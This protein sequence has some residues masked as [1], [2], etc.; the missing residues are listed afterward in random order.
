MSLTREEREELVNT[1]ATMAYGSVFDGKTAEQIE[2]DRMQLD[3]AM[4]AALCHT[5]GRCGMAVD[6]AYPD[7]PQARIYQLMM[8]ALNNG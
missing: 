4:W 2:E 6:A 3:Q 8:K 1:Y 7:T 5:T